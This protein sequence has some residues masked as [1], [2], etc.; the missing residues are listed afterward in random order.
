MTATSDDIIP[1]PSPF[2]VIQRIVKRVGC[3]A[4]MVNSFEIE[5]TGVAWSGH[6]PQDIV[7]AIQEFATNWKPKPK[8]T[9]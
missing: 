4:G 8:G 9:T 3:D 1:K 2:G 5:I 7:D 6:N